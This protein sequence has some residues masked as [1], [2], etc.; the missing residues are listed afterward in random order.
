MA[1]TSYPKLAIAQNAR[2]GVVRS[3][4]NAPQ[5]AEISD[6]LQAAGV[7]YCV[8]NLSDLKAGANLSDL[9]I[10]FLP[11]IDNLNEVQVAGLENWLASG[12]RAIA[13]GP[14]GALSPPPAREK[15]RSL[16]GA[17]WGFSLSNAAPLEP[18][19]VRE[20]EWVRQAPP[21]VLRGGVVIPTGLNSQ[22][23]AVWRSDGTPP[24]V[25]VTDRTAFLGWRWGT[26]VV[27]AAD[28]DVSW[29]QATLNR[30]GGVAGASGAPQEPCLASGGTARTAPPPR[31]VARATPPTPTPPAVG[32]RGTPISATQAQQMRQELTEAIARWESAL[33]MAE[34]A[35][36]G[37]VSMHAASEQFLRRVDKGTNPTGRAGTLN[38]TL[39]EA[40]SGLQAFDR[41]LSDRDYTRA[42]QQV[43]QVRNNLLKTYPSDRPIRYPEVRA[44][45][46]DRGTIVKARSKA[47]LV[48]IFDRLQAAGI[49]TLFFETVNASYPIYPSQIAPEQNPLTR[50]WDPL[51]AAIELA[52]ERGMELHAWVWIFA[53]ANQRHNTILGQPTDYPGP[54]LSRH[55]DWI[56]T[57]RQGSRFERNQKAFFDP[58][59]PQVRQYLL[60][61]LE[62]IATR[63]AVDGIQ[64]DY[65]RYPFQDPSVNQTYGYGNAARSQFQ[66]LAGVD[67]VTLAPN[68]PLWERWTQ[69][70]IQQVDSFVAEA[71]QRLRA[72]RPE[73]LLSAAVF[74]IPRAERLVRLQQ[75][76]ESWL[77]RGD[78]DLLVP[79]TYA[80]ENDDFQRL[81]TGLFENQP[82]SNAL[83]LPGIRL[84]RLP[85][86]TA[87][88]R[89]QQLRDLPANGYALFAAENLSL[90]VETLL[91]QTQGSR[92]NVPTDPLPQRQPFQAANLRYQTLHREWVFLLQ[93][94]QLNVEEVALKQWSL[95]ADLLAT[96][97]NKLAETPNVTNLQAAQR[98]L[99]SFEQQFGTWTRQYA[100]ESPERVSAWE[101]RLDAI[102]RLLRYGQNRGF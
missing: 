81:A 86:S 99:A 90:N 8:V 98:T 49:N 70:R 45:W 84:L 15:L 37:N 58:A 82:R 36:E 65:I 39:A 19:R 33:L 9:K 50:G 96:A 76:W 18:L 21:N 64:L 78:L 2:L 3:Q 95:Q 52:H 23:A 100:Q 35:V 87:A 43:E 20:Q 13:T 60:S 97:L 66:Q 101:N 4:E 46:F 25:V 11:N 61:L 17:Y 62:E 28:F 10:L 83:L 73:L 67:P 7:D 56:A 38:A 63:Y 53:A 93:N 12:G 79:M 59:N 94:G 92:P 75:N 5:W 89:L 42:R 47:D 40:R 29:L 1:L 71:A 26:Q 74:P 77:E 16:F 34:V 30:Y 85:V 22:T 44:I 6:R 69:F 72:K 31:P 51:A 80:L 68:S 57:D 41:A 27:A 14:T 24:A 102:A 32:G 55:P 88:D 54:V 48:P 91:R